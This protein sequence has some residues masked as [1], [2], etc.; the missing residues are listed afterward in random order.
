[1]KALVL[2]AGEGTRL[3]PLTSNV[4]KPLLLVAGKPFLSHIFEAL[5]VGGVKDVAL[6]VGWKANRVKEFYGDGSSVGLR[7]TYLEQKQRL[8]TANAVGHAEGVMDE[9]FFCVNGDVVI[10]EH[11]VKAMRNMY[12][13]L[14]HMVMAGVTVTNPSAYGVIE[15][16]EGMLERIIEKPK[17]PPSDLINAGMYVFTPEIFEEIRR[18]PKSPRGEYEVTDTVTSVAHTKGVIIHRITTDWIDVGRPWDLL[19]AN[20]IYLSRMHGRVDGEVE[21]GA[22]L[23][24]DV[25]VEKGALV[26]AGSYILGPTYVSRGCEV[27]PNCFIRAGTC[28][29]PNSKVGA[30]VEIK[31]SIIMAGSHVPH[32]NYVGDSIIGERCNLGAGTKVANLRFDDRNVKVSFGGTVIDSGRR[33]LGVIMGDNVKTGIN[34]MIDAGTV[35]WE[36]SLIGPGA[37]AK[38][39]IGP[40]SRVF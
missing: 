40:G 36:D 23:A 30:S 11:D 32:H 25:V 4:P 7:I 3:R 8:G 16:R 10:S 24:G 37:L 38:G 31:N 22:T 21:P 6:L 13:S 1:M 2:A 35:I 12:E 34:A 20:E 39:N 29:G 33:K 18:T 17:Q 19:K 14:G 28:L 9:P 26:R 27:G 5:K 15:E